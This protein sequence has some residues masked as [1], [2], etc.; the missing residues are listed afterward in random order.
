MLIIL[1][2]TNWTPA[3]FIL[4][5]VPGLEDIHMW[6]SF[7]FC[8]MY[9]VAM[10]GNCGLLY[11]I[12]YEDTLH[13]PMYYFLA[14]LSLTDIAMCSSTIPKALCIFWFHL[15]EISFGE[16][17]VQMFFIHTF[18]GMDSGVLML[19]A[20]DRYVAICYPLRYSTI[21]TNPVIA[22]VGLATFLRAVLLI[23]PFTVLT[24]K[25]PYCRG[26]IIP[27]TYCDHMSVAKLSCGNVKVNAI[28]GLTV[29]LLI[30]G[31]DI[32]CITVSYTMIIRA[33]LSLSSADA[34]QKAFSTCTAHICT[35]VFS[36]SL[37]FFSFFSHRFGGHTIP[38]SCHIIVAN[39]YLLLPPT[40]NPIVYGVKTKQIRDCVIRIL[41]GSKDIKPQGV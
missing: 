40:M 15:K 29:A 17:L 27:H 12:R 39:I 4:S 10:V 33:V 22:K 11:L 7:P 14:L 19:M 25:L 8:S 35:I 1:N 34:R 30:G 5:G 18:T 36:Y 20:L 2:K 31:F 41:S 24:K 32:L 37:A 28:Y 21:L 38:P 3:S 6:I 16:C 23:I 13:R 9:M 26:N